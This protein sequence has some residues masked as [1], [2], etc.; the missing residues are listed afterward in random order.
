M[1]T[2]SPHFIQQEDLLANFLPIQ[3]EMQDML[4][5]E[6]LFKKRR[7]RE[8]IE[9][10]FMFYAYCY[11]RYKKISK[12]SLAWYGRQDH[13]TVLHAIKTHDNLTQTDH[14]YKAKTDHVF[15][16]LDGI[17]K[18]KTS[19]KLEDFL[20]KYIRNSSQN[21]LE[22]IY[23]KIVIQPAGILDVVDGKENTFFHVDDPEIEKEVSQLETLNI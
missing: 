16:R 9:A 14:G 3:E 19:D 10:R 6:D 20:V 23:N 13:A 21:H 8:L 18:N 7:F 5:I 22:E 2:Y 4:G 17:F 11:S 15:S 12:S 1:G